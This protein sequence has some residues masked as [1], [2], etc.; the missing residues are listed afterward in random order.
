MLKKVLLSSLYTC[1]ILSADVTLTEKLLDEDIGQEQY[2]LFVTNTQGVS[3]EGLSPKIVYE[4]NLYKRLRENGKGDKKEYYP[5]DVKEAISGV[6]D[7]EIFEDWFKEVY[8]FRRG[9]GA[10]GLISN[11]KDFKDV[12]EVLRVSEYRTSEGELIT[13]VHKLIQGED[14]KFFLGGT[15]LE[16]DYETIFKSSDDTSYQYHKGI[17]SIMYT[18]Q[19]EFN[20]ALKQKMIDSK[21]KFENET[22]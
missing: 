7:L 12:E 17:I 1:A 14:S 13:T 4:G 21:G 20:K 2:Q 10:Y 15:E 8:L 11:F 19:R 16:D 9:G 18:T 5:E 6:E 3:I 22:Y